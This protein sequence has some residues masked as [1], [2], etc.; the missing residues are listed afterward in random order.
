MTDTDAEERLITGSDED[1]LR[2]ALVL[3]AELEQYSAH[4]SNLY[5]DYF[6]P[7]A[8]P[9]QIY[10]SFNSDLRGEISLLQKIVNNVDGK[11]K[12]A[13]HTVRSSN[14]PYFEAL[15]GTAKRSSE[16]IMLR[17]AVSSATYP[18][19]IMAPGTRIVRTQGESRPSKHCNLVVDIVADGGQ[20]W[21]KVSSMTNRRLIFDM[22]REAVFCGDDSE[23]EDGEVDADGLLQSSD[24]DI[25]LIKL[26]KNLASAAKGYRIRTKCPTPYL[27][28][29]RMIE[30]EDPKV[31]IILNTCRKIGVHIIC[32]NELPPA[33]ELSADVLARMSPNPK[34]RFSETL[35]LDTSVLI[36]LASDFSHTNV[37]KHPWF[38][39]S[40]LDHADLESKQ[41]ALS[42]FY[43]ILGAHSLVCTS[44]AEEVLRH[45]VNTIATDD[46]KA[47][48]E[49]LVW[50]DP[51]WSREERLQKLQSLSIHNVPPGLQLPVKV[52]NFND[53]T[54]APL[55]PSVVKE[56]MEIIPNPGRSVLM[57]GWA[58]EQ[59][60]ITCNSV[61]V[62]QLERSLETLPD[63]GEV[64]WPSIWPVPTS[65]P[66]VGTPPP[67][68]GHKRVRRH[69]GDCR[70]KCTCGVQ[71]LYG[72]QEDVT[73]LPPQAKDEQYK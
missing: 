30:G 61:A 36:G 50:G 49:C 65:R 13:S 17:Y 3:Q 14:L 4:L 6:Q 2:R 57:Y 5:A 64:K 51:Q 47:R 25:P 73:I 56:K 48:I 21:W 29:P 70:I 58:T 22:A 52:V 12:D 9:T 16:I 60:T 1:L 23:D 72:G 32:G 10:T 8:V 63:L 46:E 59:T 28:L 53:K 24:A 40:H 20:S 33:P 19:Q 67:E 55:L 31:D 27:V 34:A 71:E 35:N 69:I 41:P 26:A 37:P 38:K 18:R 45:I 39:Q 15:W 62:K 43:P 11:R 54:D 7:V 44:E 68:K 66:L 42:L